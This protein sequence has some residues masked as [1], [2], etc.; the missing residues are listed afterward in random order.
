MK[1]HTQHLPFCVLN[2]M[3]LVVLNY[4]HG[5]CFREWKAVD[6][7]QELISLLII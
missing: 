2:R 1:T 4:T 5:R 6:L 7:L 3:S